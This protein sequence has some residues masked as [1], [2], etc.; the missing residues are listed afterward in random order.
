MDKYTVYNI[1]RMST[2]C[3]KSY[4]NK[5]GNVLY[6]P[7]PDRQCTVRIKTRQAMYCT[8]QNKT[9]NVLYVPK[10]DR[11]CTV[12]IKT[13]QAIYCTYNVI[14]RRVRATIVAVVLQ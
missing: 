11:Q 4:Q 3:R 6:V 10:P 8:Y 14:L 12:R 9:G 2:I 1:S 5:T 7:K 13:R